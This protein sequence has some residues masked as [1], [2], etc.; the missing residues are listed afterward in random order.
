MFALGT[1]ALG[2]PHLDAALRGGLAHGAVHEV[3]ADPAHPASAA[4]FALALAIRACGDRSRPAEGGQ[5]ELG[6]VPIDGGTSALASNPPGL[7]PWARPKTQRAANSVLPEVVL[8]VGARGIRPRGSDTGI[9]DTDITA[10]RTVVWVRQ[11]AAAME[12]GGVYGPGLAAFG[13]DPARLLLVHLRTAIDVM[14]AALEATRCAAV[15]AV[16]IETVDRGAKIDLTATRRLKLAAEKGGVT[17]VLLRAAG[18]TVAGAVETRWR[19]RPAVASQDRPRFDITLMRHRA[20]VPE[21]RWQVEWDHEQRTFAA[22]TAAAA[23][24]QPLV[25]I[26]PRRPLAA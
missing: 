14:R 4:G 3:L 7:T 24:S 20:G 2:A 17:A 19:V 6:S 11:E 21:M 26:P 5:E 13:F 8:G 9:A 22:A 16:I 15:G 10:A 12:A 25:P 18:E 1:F 23:L